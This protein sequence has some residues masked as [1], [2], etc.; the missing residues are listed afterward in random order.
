MKNYVEEN[1]Q[2]SIPLF[3]IG[4][5]DKVECLT[6]KEMVKRHIASQIILSL[7][8]GKSSE[9]YNNLYEE[10]LIQSEPAMDYEFANDYGYILIQGQSDNPQKVKEMLIKEINKMKSEKINEEDFNRIK[11]MIYADYVKSFNSVEGIATG[12]I[13]NFFKDINSFE[14]IEE[15]SSLSLE[16]VE[17]VL[18]EMFREDRMV[19]SVIKGK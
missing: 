5:K 1:M 17:N 16:D 11:K 10:N 12:F 14:Y 18:N 7:L 4:I 9:L 6:S 15:F 8:I 13:M 3:T 19:L 2:V